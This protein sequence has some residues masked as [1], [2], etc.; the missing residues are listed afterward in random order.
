MLFKATNFGS[1]HQEKW[2]LKTLTVNFNGFSLADTNKLDETAG[3]GKVTLK[4][5]T[6]LQGLVCD[7]NL[8]LC[9][10]EG[11]MYVI[12]TNFAYILK[13]YVFQIIRY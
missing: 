7:C 3:I 1:V 11:K 10:C 13:Q 5:F 9:H 12:V 4:L 6:K 2:S 8:V